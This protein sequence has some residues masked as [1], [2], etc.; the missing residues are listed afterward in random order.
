MFKLG[1]DESTVTG[2]TQYTSA[3]ASRPVYRLACSCSAA[4]E[5]PYSS[6]YRLKHS[7]YGL[8]RCLSR[9][10][11][12]H[13]FRAPTKLQERLNITWT[14]KSRLDWQRRRKP[15]WFLKNRRP[16][17]KV[18]SLVVYRNHLLPTPVFQFDEVQVFERFAGQGSW[19]TWE[20]D[21]TIIIP[22]LFSFLD[23]PDIRRG[24]DI[25]FALYRYHHRSLPGRSRLSWLRNM[26]Y[27]IIQQTV[28]QDPRL[29]S[30][31]YITKDTDARENTGFLHLDLNTTQ[32]VKDSSGSNLLSS[33]IALGDEQAD[34]CTNLGSEE[35]GGTHPYAPHWV[36]DSPA[37]RSSI[38]PL[39]TLTVAVDHYLKGTL[40]WND[41]AACHRD[42]EAPLREP[43][44]QAPRYGLPG[45]RFPG[46]VV[47]GSSSAIGD[48]LVGRRK[49]TDPQAIQERDAKVIEQYEEAFNQLERT[50]TKAFGENSYFRKKL[51]LS[52]GSDDG[53]DGMEETEDA[54]EDM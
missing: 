16:Q 17:S 25:E 47:I 38:V 49:W 39:P 28:R 14:N 26:F 46:S 3:R 52:V 50:E 54:D 32:Y 34:G 21:G 43:S 20:Q 9:E 44:G 2:M 37:R 19:S 45:F 23:R 29:I 7:A 53:S 12:R 48:A 51:G 33:S 22:G 41:F 5:V 42:L 10:K 40:P 36:C 35:L 4:P 30:Y 11:A 8:E 6:C 1:Q 18:D 27:S 13:T 15:H 31:P 24:I